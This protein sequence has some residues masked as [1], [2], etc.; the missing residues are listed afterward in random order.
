MVNLLPMPESNRQR[1]T[2]W[3]I[4]KG[5]PFL[6]VPVLY[7]I[8][9]TIL[10]DYLSDLLINALALSHLNSQIISTFAEFVKP[11]QTA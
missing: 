6:T 8:V 5:Q 2:V 3:A 4:K 11:F 10:V 1:S 7:Y 9:Y